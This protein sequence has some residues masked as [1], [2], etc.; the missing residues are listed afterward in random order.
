LKTTPNITDFEIDSS[1]KVIRAS[2]NQFSID[3]DKIDSTVITLHHSNGTVFRFYYAS[4]TEQTGGAILTFIPKE[5]QTTSHPATAGWE[6]QLLA[7]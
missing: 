4:M 1:N 7:G 5:D 3:Y 6:V 2:A